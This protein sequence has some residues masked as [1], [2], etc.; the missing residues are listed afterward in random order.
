MIYEDIE[1]YEHWLDDN[2]AIILWSELSE[3]NRQILNDL[4]Y[5]EVSLSNNANLD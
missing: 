3:G 2:D 1:Q 4:G 5:I